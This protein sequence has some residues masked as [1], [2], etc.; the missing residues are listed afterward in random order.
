MALYVNWGNNEIIIKMRV[1][2]F[3]M[4]GYVLSILPLKSQNVDYSVVNVP[5][6]VNLHF[7]QITNVSDYVCMPIVK[8][9][10]K[11]LN[12]ISNRIIDVSADGRKIAY[13]SYRN[14]KTNIFIKELDNK[15]GSVQRT[16]RNAVID[17]KY[18]PDGKNICFSESKGKTNQVF[19]T[20]AEKGY[21]CRQ[22]TNG[23]KD[24]SPVY[25]SDMSEIFFSRQETNDFS[26]WGFNVA[27]NYLSSY[28]PGMNPCPI[29]G[30]TAYLCV[31][32]NDEGKGEIWKINYVTGTEEYLISNPEKSF[33]SP[34]ISPDGKW[35]LLVGESRI[36]NENFTYLNTDLYVAKIDGTEL[37]QITYHAADDL[38]PVWSKDGKKIYFIS[39]RGSKDGIANIWQIDFVY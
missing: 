11:T 32:F 15:G 10:K 19:V 28:S 13:L 7:K 25:S 35:I 34:I 14:D 27:G 2:I 9:T 33:A 24:Y 17:F 6:E 30:E 31:R 16:Q 22:I 5:E 36:I 39:Q 12:W 4:L 38:S 23:N 8:R 37:T 29:N 21:I 3:L 26:I 20:N 1:L 18:S